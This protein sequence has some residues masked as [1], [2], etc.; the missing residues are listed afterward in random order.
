MKKLSRII[1]MMIERNN[2]S[3]VYSRIIKIE[4]QL[5]LVIERITWMKKI[6][7]DRKIIQQWIMT[8]FHNSHTVKSLSVI[9]LMIIWMLVLIIFKTIIILRGTNI[10]WQTV[11]LFTL[12]QY[13]FHVC[14]VIK[15]NNI[16]LLLIHC[17]IIVM[18][19]ERIK[20][21]KEMTKV[22]KTIYRIIYLINAIPKE[23]EFIVDRKWK[24]K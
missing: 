16:S 2:W 6:V 18:L 22:G 19:L 3:I 13:Q 8:T 7:R 1:M 14:I 24:M 21:L 4:S 20:K 11:L 5:L 9:I 12:H 15:T 23:R 10:Q 17:R